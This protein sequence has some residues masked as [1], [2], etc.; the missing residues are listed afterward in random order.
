M[1]KNS[2]KIEY[3]LSAYARPIFLAI[4]EPDEDDDIQIVISNLAFKTMSVGQRISYIFNLLK[5]HIPE[6]LDNRLIIVQAYSPEEIEEV[7][8]QVFFPELDK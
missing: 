4:T 2:T 3:V 6:V 1:E 5:K 8:D 7:L